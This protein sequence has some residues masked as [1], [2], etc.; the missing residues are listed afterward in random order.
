MKKTAAF[1]IIAMILFVTAATAVNLFSA[2]SLPSGETAI[3]NFESAVSENLPFRK[4]LSDLM[5]GLRYFSGVR[6]FDNVYIGSKGSLLRDIERPTSRTFSSAKNYI[7][8]FAEKRQTKPY[9]MLV[10]TSAAVLQ[11]EIENYSSEDIYNQRSMITR[12][13]AEFEGKVR[14]TDI[15]QTLYDHRDEYIY[16]HTE[17]LPTSL[18]KLISA[19]LWHAT[20]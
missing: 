18:G 9:F 5:N 2:D 7:I 10:P 13:Y 15:Y 6:R 16:Y 1:L 3:Q 4:E 8:S 17:D 12:M 14:T 11:Q 20:K 19:T